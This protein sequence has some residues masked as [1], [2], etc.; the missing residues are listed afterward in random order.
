MQLQKSGRSSSMAFQRLLLQSQTMQATEL[1]A[2]VE[3]HVKE[4]VLSSARSMRECCDQGGDPLRSVEAMR[5]ATL[6][7]A[8]D[9]SRDVSVGRGF[10]DGVRKSLHAGFEAASALLGRGAAARTPS[11]EAGS[12]V[13]ESSSSSKS[14]RSSSSSRI[15]S[16]GSSSS[17][18][19]LEGSCGEDDE[20]G[21]GRRGAVGAAPLSREVLAKAVRDGCGF[22]LS[23][24]PSSIQ[25]PEAGLGVFCDGSAPVGA[26]VAL[27]PGICYTRTEYERMP[28]YP[29]IDMDNSFLSSRS[30]MAIIDS[31][32]WGMGDSGERGST[33]GSSNHNSSSN[34]SSSSSSHSSSNHSSSSGGSS[35]QSSSSGGS[36]NQSSSSHSSSNQSSS[37]S[38]SSTEGGLHAHGNATTEAENRS[39]GG[40]REGSSSGM[41]ESPPAAAGRGPGT[42]WFSGVGSSCARVALLEGR[43]PLALG[44]LVNHPGRGMHPNVLE[45]SF[46]IRLT[47]EDPL[48]LRPYIPNIGC[49]VRGRSSSDAAELIGD[50]HVSGLAL[51]AIKPLNDG[52]EVLQNY[53]MNPHVVRPEWYVPYD[54]E[55]EHRR[56]AKLEFVSKKSLVRRKE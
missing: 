7:L 46:D 26:L 40:S 37:N 43:H 50:T 15:S 23:V 9:K 16:S 19:V 13:A 1:R 14:S 48:W 22:S 45:V 12:D 20:L 44:H 24:R 5:A 38:S 28:N 51:I 33:D 31:K 41:A 11:K 47:K 21:W 52:D 10:R 2:A 34:H 3:L 29:Q 35:N 36:S 42:P 8:L 56:W 55:A 39:S 17:S 6:A 18:G 30:D 53:R 27:V 25:H 4:L 49:G 54:L 32:P